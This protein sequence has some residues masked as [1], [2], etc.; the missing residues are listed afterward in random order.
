MNDNRREFLKLALA[1][2]APASGSLS[3]LTIEA[4]ISRWDDAIPIGNGLTGRIFAF[5]QGSVLVVID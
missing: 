3:T 4:P 2:A 5:D 1:A